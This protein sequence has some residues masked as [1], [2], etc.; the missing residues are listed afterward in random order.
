MEEFLL[1][2]SGNSLGRVRMVLVAMPEDGRS[3][4]RGILK[5]MTSGDK[6]T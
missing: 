6:L 1:G 5:R 3:H 4:K 2:V